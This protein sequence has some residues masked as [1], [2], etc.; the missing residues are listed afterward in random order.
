M[1]EDSAKSRP[2]D[3]A[4]RKRRAAPESRPK[5]STASRA[6]T[7]ARTTASSVASAD[8]SDRSRRA[9]T[10]GDDPARDGVR[11]GVV[12]FITITSFAGLLALGATA[13]HVGADAWLNAGS[14]DRTIGEYFVAGVRL[15]WAMLRALYASGV[16]DPLF[17]ALSM[18][19]LIPPIA[20]LAAARPVRPGENRATTAMLNAARLGAA[21]IVAASTGVAIRLANIARPTI[22]EIAP[23]DDWLD[24]VQG[25]AAADAVSMA[26][27][28]LLAVL[29]F[30]LP[31]DRW[32]RALVGTVAIATAMAATVAAAASSGVAAE[33][34]QPRPVVRSEVDGTTQ[35]RLLVGSTIDGSI[36]LL[37]SGTPAMIVIQPRVELAVAGRRSIIETLDIAR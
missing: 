2:D 29:V 23:G 18:A 24:R 19:L 4:N 14:M 37:E 1:T 5:A 22:A 8:A 26:F 27:A 12:A 17:F 25:L 35:E 15:P 13:V 33:V 34:A 30:R 20:G 16:D 32:V 10:S 21:L 3:D 7:A 28:I 11:L 6:I 9:V 31:V 36:V